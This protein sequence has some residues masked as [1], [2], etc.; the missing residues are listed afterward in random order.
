MAPW[1]LF[2]FIGTFDLG[3]YFYAG[4]CTSNAARVAAI[5]NAVSL[6]SATDSAGA[7]YNVVG[8]MNK[9]P[10]TQALV[11]GSYACPSSP[12][13]GSPIALVTVGTE[14]ESDG[15]TAAVVQVG[16]LPLQMIPIPGVINGQMTIYRT[17]KVPIL[18]TTPP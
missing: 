6:S 4:I 15:S 16:Y 7:C 8:E 3:F 18:N 14:V 17:A 11:P 2:L 13:S 1:I 5:A 12:S 9:L 10:N